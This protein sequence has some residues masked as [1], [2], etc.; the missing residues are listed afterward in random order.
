MVGWRG[1]VRHLELVDDPGGDTP[2]SPTEEDMLVLS[3][4]GPLDDDVVLRLKEA[5]G[6]RVPSCNPYGDRSGATFEDPDG[7]RPALR[8]C[9]WR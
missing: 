2:P 6:R 4:D 9:G 8:T 5:G 3:L 1:A 7:Y